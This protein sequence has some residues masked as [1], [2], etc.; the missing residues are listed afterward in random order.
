MSSYHVWSYTSDDLTS[1][2]NTVKEAVV[3]HLYNEG[4]L[5][6]DADYGEICGTFAVIH[7]RKGSLGRWFD[8]LRGRDKEDAYYITIVKAHVP[9]EPPEPTHLRPVKDEDE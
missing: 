7:A 4:L 5:P 2:A 6:E 9:P 8:R 3:A 1:F